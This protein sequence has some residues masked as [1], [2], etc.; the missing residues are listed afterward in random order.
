[1]IVNEIRAYGKIKTLQDLITIQKA[2]DAHGV[3]AV[4]INESGA[5]FSYDTITATA[6]AINHA[7]AKA[8]LK[9]TDDEFNQ[10]IQKRG[11]LE[12]SVPEEVAEEDTSIDV[13]IEEVFV[14]VMEDLG[15]KES[16]FQEEPVEETPEDGSDEDQALD[17]SNSEVQVFHGPCIK[18]EDCS[19]YSD[20]IAL[21]KASIQDKLE[22]VEGFRDYLL[23]LLKVL[24]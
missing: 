9:L 5:I 6:R 16:T 2:A 20:K 4:G 12:F 21:A 19:I 11:E 7:T 24:N 18:C 8:L 10:F 17:E 23:H 14:E 15:E 3:K 1:M 22:K 13:P